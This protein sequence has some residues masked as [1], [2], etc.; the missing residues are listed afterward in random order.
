MQLKVHPATATFEHECSQDLVQSF[1]LAMDLLEGMSEVGGLN[2]MAI[3][4]VA[5]QPK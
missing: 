5:W 4:C 2:F 1:V 3:N